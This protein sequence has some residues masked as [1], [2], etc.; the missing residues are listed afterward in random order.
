M[1]ARPAQ[2]YVLL[3]A[4][5]AGL[6]GC[7][8]DARRDDPAREL[9]NEA[10]RARASARDAEAAG[11]PVVAPGAATDDGEAWTV[12]PRHPDAKA[13]AYAVVSV[14]DLE[15]A[16]GLWADRFGM[17][18]VVRR[19][20]TDPG[21]ARLWGLG[22]AD[23]VD[24]ALL[25]TP[26]VPQGG[27]HLVQFRVPGG[28]VR[29]G[30]SATD[31]VPKSV[32]VAVRGLAAR[33]DELVAAGF[34]FRAPLAHVESD[35]VAGS[36]AQ[37]PSADGV[38]IAMLEQDG[39][40]VAASEQGYGIATQVTVVSADAAREA[41]FL[42]QLLGVEQI[43]SRRIAGPAIERA[44]GLPKGAAVNLRL[45]GDPALEFG[46]VECVQY[47]KAAGQDLYPRTHAPARGLLSLTWFVPD[48][49][50]VLARAPAGSAADLGA[51]DTIYGH[52]RAARVTTPAGLRLEFIE[53]RP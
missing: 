41:A 4:V 31:L 21:L 23:I 37:L 1:P 18:V 17:N 39:K 3:F 46:R 33:Y 52:A 32:A 42:Q 45:L 19:Q 27:L 30:A 36:Q 16:L 51:S 44:A 14:T 24:Q 20:G 28:A 7:A 11:A 38:N 10:A 50:A 53:R 43:S 5:L 25:L 34:K 47:E 8:G 49:A 13:F 29:E 26:G 6:A 22:A 9:R 40:L 2:L 48:V 15:R 12:P 35:G